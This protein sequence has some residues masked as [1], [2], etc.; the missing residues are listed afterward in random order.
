VLG[1]HLEMLR[2]GSRVM[3]NV[4]GRGSITGRVVQLPSWITTSSMLATI[5]LD[6]GEDLKVTDKDILTP[7]DDVALNLSV[8]SEST[9]QQLVE[10][11][12]KFFA[13]N[14]PA[15]VP[16]TIRHSELGSIVFYQLQRR[17]MSCLANFLAAS[18]S[19]ALSLTKSTSLVPLLGSLSLSTHADT[20]AKASSALNVNLPYPALL[21]NGLN[22]LAK[23]CKDKKVASSAKDLIR[24]L[25][26]TLVSFTN[27]S[28]N[29]CQFLS[30]SPEENLLEVKNN[31]A[32]DDGLFF[33]SPSPSLVHSFFC[34]SL[35]LSSG[36][37]LY[38][39][40]AKSP[41]TSSFSSLLLFSYGAWADDKS[42][43]IVKS[44]LLPSLAFRL[45]ANS[46]G[47][48][49]TFELRDKSEKVSS[50]QFSSPLYFAASTDDKNTTTNESK[51]QQQDFDFRQGIPSG[52]LKITEAKA[53]TDQL[54]LGWT[55]VLPRSYLSVPVQTS[56]V[57]SSSYT[58]QMEVCFDCQSF[59][60]FT[61]LWQVRTRGFLGVP[62]RFR[63]CSY[64]LPFSSSDQH[65]ELRPF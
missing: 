64:F 57:G 7:V 56:A 38:M 22:L 12:S 30:V 47:R 4:A 65:Q 26:A 5:R 17:L 34:F 18:P 41:A 33:S 52:V 9:I 36:L 44:S 10:S 60:A 54:G 50:Y 46:N 8:F 25:S 1:G 29:V 63:D 37:S 16:S 28:G 42:L 49:F 53:V 6:S 43:P 11:M 39:T 45:F 31:S 14:P 2:M 55:T 59:P 3:A 23:D 35:L 15:Q 27:L 20:V 19:T 51:R 58:V 62:L 21:F 40:V 32:N 24:G 13:K 61:A 48:S